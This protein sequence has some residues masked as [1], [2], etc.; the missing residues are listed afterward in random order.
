MGRIVN[1][2][3]QCG[4][5]GA[6]RSNVGRIV[7]PSNQ[8]GDDGVLRSNVGRIVNP[9]N[10]CGDDGRCKVTWDG[11]SIRPT[12]NGKLSRPRRVGF[13]HRQGLTSVGEAHPTMAHSAP[14]E[15]DF[16]FSTFRHRHARES[17][18]QRYITRSRF[19]RY[20]LPSPAGPPTTGL[21]QS[22]RSIS[23]TG[24]SA[25]PDGQASSM[26]TTRPGLALAPTI[27]P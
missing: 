16:G 25:D 23:A 19:R 4:D 11:F 8:C 7:N 18:L 26:T 13:A 2:S 5:D 17:P 22:R 10:Q 6:L 3:N 1:P 21:G 27:V 20:A 24:F 12:I 14:G 9:S 15:V